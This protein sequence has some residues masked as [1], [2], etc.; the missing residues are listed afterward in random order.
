[1]Q[2]VLLNVLARTQAEVSLQRKK[3][4]TDL[5]SGKQTL[6]SSVFLSSHSSSG[7]LHKCF[8]NFRAVLLFEYPGLNWNLQAKMP[9]YD[10][11]TH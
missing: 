8:S 5:F 6:G 9:D 7:Q 4:I 10:C 1:M 3:R 2:G 11:K